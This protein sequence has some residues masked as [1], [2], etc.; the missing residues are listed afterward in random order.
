MMDR[1]TWVT[2]L[3]M[4]GV[5]I[6]WERFYMEPRRQ[7]A[8]TQTAAT[9]QPQG[10]ASSSGLTTAP[11]ATTPVV[12][13]SVVIDLGTSQL[14]VSNRSKLFKTW[15]LTNYREALSADART[16]DMLTVGHQLDGL[17]D[18]VFDR[19][20]YLYLSQVSGEIQE[21]ADRIVWSYEDA[22]VKIIREY[23]KPSAGAHTVDV[24]I[25]VDFKANPAGNMFVSLTAESKSED[26]DLIDRRLVYS[27]EKGFASA[28]LKGT[29]D[30]SAIPFPMKWIGVTN[31]YFLISLLKD[32]GATTSGLVQGLAENK[33]RVMMVYPVQQGHVQA[34]LK[35]FFGPKQ[36]G[37]LRKVDAS[38]ESTID[39]GWF[40]LFAY[41]LLRFMKI[42]N[43]LVSNWGVAIILLTL[44]V[45]LLTFPLTYKSMKSMK[46]MAK[47][48]PQIQ[49]LRERY[50][51]DKE[52]LNREM[53]LLMRNQGYNPVAG[54][55]PI[56]IQMPVFFALY[57]VLYSSTEL[58][59]AP[60]MFWIH[61]LSA[62][63]PFYITPAILTA[64]MFI[65]QK[66]TPNTAS[67]PMQAKM[68]QW[69]PVMFGVFM[70]Q[71]PSGLT[72]YMLVNALAGI[73]QQMLLNKKLDQGH[74]ATAT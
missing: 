22:N 42:L 39:F 52:A 17:G 1:R 37:L 7:A 64:V 40:T 21:F 38:L 57:R 31:R 43:D 72:L 26:A 24:K 2:V 54:C 5:F 29:I 14:E 68:L 56:L 49:K 55:L 8:L 66:L 70:L 27:S 34:E 11:V 53:M 62:K 59:Q 60:F 73:F 20:E 50:A 63:D 15:K 16:V 61:D 32:D 41:P 74:A 58:Y 10:T 28:D 19:P 67:D 33:G 48:N 4:L 9:T 46:Q 12:E 45:K 36:L 71:L 35:A 69:M 44:A 47:L 65:Q 23:F 6:A 13:K 18:L 30:Q 51:D 3:V 25:A